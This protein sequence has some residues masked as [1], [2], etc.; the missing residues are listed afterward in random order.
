MGYMD[1]D[2]VYDVGVLLLAGGVQGELS[3]DPSEG[4]ELRYFSL[5]ALPELGSNE[6]RSLEPEAT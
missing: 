1:G 5:D 4:L 3:P 2:Q 6:P